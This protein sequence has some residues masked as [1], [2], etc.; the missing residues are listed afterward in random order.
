MSDSIIASHE[1]DEFTKKDDSKDGVD[2]ITQALEPSDFVLL[3]LTTQMTV[4]RF[5][6]LIHEMRLMVRTPDF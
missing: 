3:N 2:C 4:K 1:T 5:V 6:E